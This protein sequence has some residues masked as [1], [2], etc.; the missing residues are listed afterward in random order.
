MQ[1]TCHERRVSGKV[2]IGD[3][4]APSGFREFC[5]DVAESRHVQVQAADGRP[6]EVYVAVG[7]SLAR[8]DLKLH[9]LEGEPAV[10]HF[11]RIEDIPYSPL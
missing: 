8:Y 3:V 4:A 9:Q 11:E 1:L 10:L 6:H 2:R 7:Q 5:P